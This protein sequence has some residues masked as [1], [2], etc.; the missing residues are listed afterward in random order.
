MIRK[1]D[2]VKYGR[3]IIRKL[4]KTGC[5]GT[6]SMY[7]ENTL[8]GLPDKGIGNKVLTALTKQRICL[9]KKKEHGWKY[10]LN[11]QRSDKIREIIKETGRSSIIPVLLVL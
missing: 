9:R 3:F 8:D 5:Y 7:G 6:G 11:K 2:Y 1:S 10:C 4:H